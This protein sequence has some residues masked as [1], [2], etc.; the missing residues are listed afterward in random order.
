MSEVRGNPGPATGDDAEALRR[1]TAALAHDLMAPLQAILSEAEAL[2][3]APHDPGAAA[4]AALRIRNAAL[5]MRGIAEGTL[6]LLGRRVLQDGTADV[7]STLAE[8]F[9]T[10]FPPATPGVPVRFLAGSGGARVPLPPAALWR[11]VQNLVANARSAAAASG[12]EVEVATS[13]EPSTGVACIAVRDFGPG[14]PRE[15]ARRIEDPRDQGAPGPE[16]LGLLVAGT[17][18]AAAGGRLA[19]SREPDGST[20]IRI[21]VPLR[22]PRGTPETAGETARPPATPA[23]G[24]AASGRVLVIDDDP[25]LREAMGL[26]LGVLGIPCRMADTGGAGLSLLAAEPFDAVIADVRLPDV[27]APDLFEEAVR[28][29][30]DLRPAIIFATGD[31]LSEE[32]RR[33][34]DATGNPWLRK[35]FS[36]D[37]LREAIEL[38]RQRRFRPPAS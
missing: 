37:A 31:L 11:I 4:R 18:A 10:V 2:A 6:D 27:A 8:G 7:D 33:F 5:L 34:L 29:R 1:A 36:A 3:A 13:R 25:S 22:T 38:A 15:A 30:P 23:A 28:R 35:P 12:R 17:L 32:T 16:G 24:D 19:H 9:A 21:L 26:V 20:V 14:L